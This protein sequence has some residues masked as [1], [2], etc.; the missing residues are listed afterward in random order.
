MA[1]FAAT[2]VTVTA[3]TP[4][5]QERLRSGWLSFPTLSF[6]GGAQTYP[7]GGIPLPAIGKL[8]NFKTAIRGGM[9][10]DQPIDGFVYKYDKTN[11]KL[12]IYYGNYDAADGPLIEIT[13]ATHA[14]TSLTL[15]LYG[16]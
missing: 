16:H 11:H 2:D 6:G 10:F 1:D 4:L 13:G 8:G 12:L 3:L 5:D 7:A 14:A 15:F 9:V